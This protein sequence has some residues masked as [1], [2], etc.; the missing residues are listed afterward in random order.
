MKNIEAPTAI[1]IQDRRF[2]CTRKRKQYGKG[3]A[4]D[5]E[6]QEVKVT[7]DEEDMGAWRGD[8]E[9]RRG[10]GWVLTNI[11]NEN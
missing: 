2:R 9:R 11:E 8:G 4:E 5:E 1:E 7:K 10:E 3:H 6:E